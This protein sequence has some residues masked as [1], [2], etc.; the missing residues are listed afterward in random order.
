V[1]RIVQD[2]QSGIF[3]PGAWIKQ[4]DLQERYRATQRVIASHIR[5]DAV[6]D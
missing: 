6:L 2:I 5:Q 1:D 3:G 4:I